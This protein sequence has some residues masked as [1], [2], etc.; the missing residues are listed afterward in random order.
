MF[1]WQTVVIVRPETLIRWHRKGFQLFWR[2]K[3]KP[4]GRPRVPADLQELIIA[5]ARSNPTWGEQRIAAELLLKLGIRL[6]PKSVSGT[7]AEKLKITTHKKTPQ[8]TYTIV[9]TGASRSLG[10]STHL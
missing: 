5:M 6:S 8:S 7:L 4:G 9:V 2:C 10:S 3:S 1:A